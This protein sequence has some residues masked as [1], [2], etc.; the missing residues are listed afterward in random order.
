MISQKD[1]LLWEKFTAGVTPLTRSTAIAAYHPTPHIKPL[2]LAPGTPTLDLHGYSLAEAHQLLRDHVSQW[3]E[4]LK[5]VTVITGKSGPMKEQVPLWAQAIS[6]VKS[7][8]PLNGGGA[9]RLWFK[10]SNKS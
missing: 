2:K 7:V 1:K 4:R 5:W 3:R 6:G 8:E 10:H 9:Y